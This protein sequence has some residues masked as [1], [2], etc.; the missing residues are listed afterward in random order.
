LRGLQFEAI[1]GKKLARPI[2]TNKGSVV[3]TAVIPA[4]REAR[5]YHS[6][7]LDLVKNARSYPKNN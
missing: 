7:R 4:T 5:E 3:F 1:L 6:S 2:S